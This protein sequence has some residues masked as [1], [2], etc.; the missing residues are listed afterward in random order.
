MIESQKYESITVVGI[1]L[2]EQGIESHDLVTP[3]EQYDVDAVR[4]AFLAIPGIDK[5]RVIVTSSIDYTD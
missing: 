1:R 4:D 3:A 5:V 2:N